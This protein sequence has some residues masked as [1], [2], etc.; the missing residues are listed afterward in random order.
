MTVIEIIKKYLTDNKYDGL[1]DGSC[2]CCGCGLSD[3][4]SCGIVSH[5]CEPGYKKPCDCGDHDFH[6][7]AEKQCTD[8]LGE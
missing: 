3:L 2:G 5:S 8:S 6:I 7:G 1:Y 4:F